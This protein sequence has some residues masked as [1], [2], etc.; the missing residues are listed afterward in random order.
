MLELTDSDLA[1]VQGGWGGDHDDWWRYNGP[2]YWY[3]NGDPDNWWYRHHHEH[4]HHRH[5]DHDDWDQH[6]V[7]QR[8]H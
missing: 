6:Q 8:H 3:Y 2:D 5:H 4:Y 7:V 1:Q